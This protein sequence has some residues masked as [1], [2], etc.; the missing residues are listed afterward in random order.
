MKRTEITKKKIVCIG[1]FL[2]CVS[3]QTSAWGLGLGSSS[4]Q[5]RKAEAMDSCIKYLQLSNMTIE[6]H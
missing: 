4:F 3:S 1:M 6:W 5:F 2:D